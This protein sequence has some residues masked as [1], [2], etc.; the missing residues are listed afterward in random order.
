M[1]GKRARR[2]GIGV[3]ERY[4]VLQQVI[5]RDHGRCVVCHELC[6]DDPPHHIFPK[7]ATK[8]PHL[9]FELDNLVTLCLPCHDRHERA[10]K[11]VPRAVL[12]IGVFALAER[13]GP[14]AVSY[15]ER[16]YPDVEGAGWRY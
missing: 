16:T 8:W 13:E 7:A 4:D 3:V 14:R 2:N 1:R 12:P 15:L 5:D 6:Y 10:Y 9:I 11:R